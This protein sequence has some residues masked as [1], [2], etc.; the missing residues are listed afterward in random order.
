MRA[1]FVFLALSIGSPTAPGAAMPGEPDA[2]VNQRSG[3]QQV[4]TALRIQ[5]DVQGTPVFVTLDDN[6][7]S[8]D[9]I[10]MLPLTLTLEDYAATEKVADLPRRLSTAGAPAAMVP[11]TGD[12]T[13]Y[14][15]W[16][17]LAIFYKDG[18]HSPGLI[19]LGGIGEQVALFRRTAPLRATITLAEE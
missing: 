7:T 2:Q 12:V 14:A 16:G 10:A 5:V 15:P 18:H 1:L 9:F 17:N 13:Y 11:R 6:Q 4:K 8:R 19:R 3:I